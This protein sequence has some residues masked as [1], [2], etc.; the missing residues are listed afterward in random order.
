MVVSVCF[1]QLYN[2][3][4]TIIAGKLVG[5]FALSAIS[6]SYPITMILMMI[7]FGCGVGC[8][9]VVSKFFG[10]KQYTR[11]K[12]C[13]ST[14]FIS[15][16]V[17]ALVCTLIAYLVAEPA[18]RA[19]NTPSNIFGDAVEYLKIYIWG[20]GFLFLY[21]ASSAMFQALGNSKTPL[22][23]LIFSSIFNIVLDLLF[24]IVFNFGVVGLAWATFTAQGLSAIMSTGLL[25]YSLKKLPKDVKSEKFVFFSKVLFKQLFI[26]AVPSILQQSFISVGQLFIQGLI[27]SYGNN[28]I[29]AFGSAFK[30]SVFC[31]SVFVA[32]SNALANY[33]S[34]NIGAAKL[35]NLKKGLKA[36]NFINLMIALLFVV[37]S[38]PLAPQLIG[39]FVSDGPGKS[40][41]IRIGAEYIY[42]VFPFYLFVSVKVTFDGFLK[43]AGDMRSFMLSTFS[44]LLLRVGFS[45]L[46]VYV[47][48][49]YLGIWW[50]WPIG[51][52]IAMFVGIACYLS[53]RWKKLYF[54]NIKRKGF[55]TKYHRKY[56]DKIESNMTVDDLHKGAEL[57]SQCKTCDHSAANIDLI[58]DTVIVKE[59]NNE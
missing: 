24:V 21:N 28:V 7:G 30:I 37:I 47:A 23:M 50:S 9:V 42:I 39:M 19:L 49:T 15:I 10:Q 14:A 48:K 34:Q 32:I 51:W 38:L 2:I 8:G 13:I 4:D 59:P 1:Q 40:E 27:N 17:L 55:A 43:G 20:I 56:Q 54:A 25:L 22:I 6:S 18:M 41:I 33:T 52:V 16:A 11:V 58:E 3:A 44:D 29:A 46:L 5:N 31:T 12:S 57:Q 53:L 45:F 36:G 35:E 26:I